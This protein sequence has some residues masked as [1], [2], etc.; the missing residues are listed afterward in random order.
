MLDTCMCRCGEGLCQLLSDVEV[1]SLLHGTSASSLN[2]YKA[3]QEH[4]ERYDV[5]VHTVDCKIFVT[6]IFHRRPFLTKIK[7]AKYFFVMY[8]DLYQVWLIKSGD[9]N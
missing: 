3:S 9:E 2:T 4:Q 7:H 1:Q 8:V 6:K 5:H